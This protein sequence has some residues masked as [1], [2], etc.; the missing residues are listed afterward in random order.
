M[1]NRRS[2]PSR[3]RA[4]ALS[5][6]FAAMTVIGGLVSIPLGTVPITM[7]TFFI[8]L[9]VLVLKRDA[10]L[11]VIIYL[12]MGLVGLPVFANG[13]SGYAVLLGPLGGFLLG[14]V[15]GSAAAG[16]LISRISRRRYGHIFTLLLCA[17]IIFAI[18]W[19]WLAYWMGWNFM[20][21]LWVGVLPF[22]PGDAMKIILAL[23]VYNRLNREEPWPRPRI[24]GD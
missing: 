5:A 20:A 17:T 19:L 23:A 13:L 11:S 3:A 12:I 14:F 4:L 24:N 22:L 7:Q 18:G 1:E 8:Y 2:D 10:F 16:G 15:V 6:A 9:G 21:A